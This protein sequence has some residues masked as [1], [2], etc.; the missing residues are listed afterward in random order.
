MSVRY[1]AGT[2]PVTLTDAAG[3]TSTFETNALG[4]VTRTRSTIIA[5]NGS[6][7]GPVEAVETR[8]YDAGGRLVTL[9]D[10]AGAVTRFEYDLAGNLTTEI[11]GLGNRTRYET[12]PAGKVTRKIRADGSI[13]QT[14]YDAAGRCPVKPIPPDT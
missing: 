13:Y 14:S 2:H 3:L 7:N 4:L 6:N 11:D 8:S 9:T 1:G 5:N 10:V 12:N